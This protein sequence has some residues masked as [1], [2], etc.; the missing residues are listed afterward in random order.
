MRHGGGGQQRDG[1]AADEQRERTGCPSR[2]PSESWKCSVDRPEGLAASGLRPRAIA[3]PGAG[4]CEPPRSAPMSRRARRSGTARRRQEEAPAVRAPGDAFSNATAAGYPL[5]CGVTRCAAASPSADDRS[6]A[7]AA[8]H[9]WPAPRSGQCCLNSLALGRERAG[10]TPPA[11]GRALPGLRAGI[12]PADASGRIL[13]DD[14]RIA[15]GDSAGARGGSLSSVGVSP[16]R[17]RAPGG[18]SLPRTGYRPPGHQYRRLRA[19]G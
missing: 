6:L 12:R 8:R 13:N 9:F 3:W 7:A 2:R 16:G 4:F 10:E 19:R 17:A 15:R 5:R 1:A 18:G 11:R 14:C